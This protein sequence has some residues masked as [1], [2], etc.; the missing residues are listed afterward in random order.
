MS[1]NLYTAHVIVHHDH[2]LLAK[3][4]EGMTKNHKVNSWTMECHAICKTI[5]FQYIKGKKNILCDSLTRIQYFDLY[6][7][8]EPEKLGYLFGKPDPEGA[9]Q[10]K[11][12]EIL[13]IT[14]SGEVDEPESVQMKVNTKE[15]VN[16]QTEQQKYMHIHKMIEKHPNKL[17]MLY[18]VREDDVLVK[19]VRTNNQKSEAVMVPEKMKNTYYMRPMKG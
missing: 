7:D 6:K 19:I 4:I 15:L 18:K 13:E 1:F 10:E 8:K 11:E 12:Y 14:H 2:K 17:G 3:F 16:M 5:E 9:N